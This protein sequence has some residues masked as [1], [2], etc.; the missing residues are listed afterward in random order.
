MSCGATTNPMQPD[1]SAYAEGPGRTLAVRFRRA[2]LITES[3]RFIGSSR[4]R[5]WTI[6]PRRPGD[7]QNGPGAKR[8]DTDKVH[9]KY[10]TKNGYKRS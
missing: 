10:K 8:N 1:W 2:G 9:L 5:S 3:K 4:H 6:E 7:Q